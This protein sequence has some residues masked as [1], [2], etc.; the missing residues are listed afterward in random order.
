M[1]IL[2]CLLSDQHVPNLPSVHHFRSDHL[3]LVETGTARDDRLA[4][5]FLTALDLGGLDYRGRFQTVPL[6]AE[7]SLPAARDA[8]GCA[9][10]KYPEAQWIANLTAGTK[11]MSMG[12]YVFYKALG[13]RLVYTNVARSAEMLDIDAYS[14]ERCAHRLTS[15][16]FLA[17][18]GFER[19]KAKAKVAESEEHAQAWWDTARKIAQRASAASVLPL[20]DEERNE[21]RLRGLTLRPRQLKCHRDDLRLAIS[22][23]FALDQVDLSGHLDSHDAEFFTDGWLEVFFW[24]LI[25]RHASA[26]DCWDVRLGPA[27]GRL[28]DSFGNEFDV[29]FMYEHALAMIECKSGAQAHDRQADILYKVEAVTRQFRAIR[30]RSLLATTADSIFDDKRAIRHNIRNRAE[31]YN[32]RIVTAAMIRQLADHPDDTALISGTLFDSRATTAKGI[33]P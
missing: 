23:A 12:T 19:G 25:A 2:L 16:E 7:D 6:P 32:C 3:V 10:E 1:K 9:H 28:G 4:E 15:A 30:V 5:R 24:G 31:T 18:Y 33:S 13:A 20:S 11:P 17:G 29:A 22:K 8:L 27:I 21:A 26:L 14:N